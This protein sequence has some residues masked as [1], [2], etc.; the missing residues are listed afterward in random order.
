MAGLY[1]HIPFCKQACY[2][3][4]FFFSTNQEQRV[5]LVQA[6][7]SEIALQKDYLSGEILETIYVGGGTPSILLASELNEI[8]EAVH[9]NFS[10]S[11]RPEI[12][13]EANPDDLTKEKLD[14]LYDAGVNRLSI[15]VQSFD[16]RVLK[17]LNRPHDNLMARCCIEDARSTGFENISID[18][19]YAIPQ[20]P[21]EDWGKDIYETLKISPQ[22]I[23]AYSLT[24]EEKT[25]F[26]KWTKQGK[27]QPVDDDSSAR[28]L[29]LLID[30][31]ESA[32]YEQYE[33]SNFSK[34]GFQSMH[35]SNYW[36]NGKYLGIGPSAHSYNGE[37]RQYN[38]SNN[39]TYLRSILQQKIPC[40]LEILT[41]QDKINEYLLTTLRTSWGADLKTLR[42][43]FSFDPIKENN[44]YIQSLQRE[45]L[46]VVEGESLKLTK[47]GRFMADKIASDLFVIEP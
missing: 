3:C 38:V 24:I 43:R 22:H 30:H 21:D 5:Q 12:T 40:T 46:I 45:G 20:R 15:G 44:D 11:D 17:S 28:Q 31:L 37:T 27:M 36:K 7:T 6:L 26:G 16:D 47:K 9:R 42:E 1:I 35:N 18:L 8:L 19:I 41:K 32:N 10:V 39:P 14:A 4:D 2:Y 13:L 23:S 25:V 34:P 33:V 29:A